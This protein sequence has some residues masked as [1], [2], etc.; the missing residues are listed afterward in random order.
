MKY[1]NF[2]LNTALIV[3]ILAIVGVFVFKFLPKPH[4]R[5]SFLFNNIQQVSVLDLAGNPIK[6]V[7][8][9]DSQKETYIMFL[10]LRNCGSCLV[11]GIEDMIRLKK[12][13][14]PA[15]II[16]VHERVD[17]ILGWSGTWEF[18]PFYMIKTADFYQQ[19]Q[20]A[21]LPVIVKV[22]NQKVTGYRYIVK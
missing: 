21:V 8:I 14:N 22:K 9:L 16:P 4:P 18:S 3:L 1:R 5:E 20:C 7:D 12:A 15:I 13:G 6:L 17:E 10:E 19:L 2:L 11:A